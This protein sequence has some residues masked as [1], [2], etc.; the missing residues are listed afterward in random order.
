MLAVILFNVVGSVAGVF[1]GSVEL[2]LL[3]SALMVGPSLVWV[4]LMR[5]LG[6]LTLLTVW[7]T[8][9]PIYTSLPPKISGW[10]ARDALPIHLLPVAIGAWALWVI[11]SAQ[12]SAS[13]ESQA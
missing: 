3:L 13:T 4:V 11:L 6:F 1:L 12:R 5:R 10:M 2:R 7:V 9:I 8:T